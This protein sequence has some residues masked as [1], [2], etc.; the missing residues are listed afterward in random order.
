MLLLYFIKLLQGCHS[1]LVDKLLNSRFPLL[2]FRSALYCGY[3]R[4]SLI[5]IAASN[6]NIECFHE[7]FAVGYRA[8]DPSFFKSSCTGQDKK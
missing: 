8:P 7:Y 2:R 1:Q 6:E 5:K 4:V 3:S